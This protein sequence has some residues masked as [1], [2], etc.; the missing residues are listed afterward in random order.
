M[1][2]SYFNAG[3]VVYSEDG[4]AIADTYTAIGRLGSNFMDI[5]T[6]S[7]ALQAGESNVGTPL[8][9]PKLQTPV[10]GL[11]VPV[12]D[13]RGRV[14]G[15][16]TGII[17]LSTPNFLN[18]VSQH[19]YGKTGGYMLVAQK[20][21]MIVTATD[22]SRAME[23]LPPP[24]VN[25][26]VD[27]L[28]SGTEGSG[29]ATNALGVEVLG[30]AKGIPASGWVV[31]ATL[32]TA[33]AFASIHN[34]KQ[35]MWRVTGGLT[36]LAGLLAW[37][38]IRRLLAPLAT[39]ASTLAGM[40]NSENPAQHLP[41]GRHDEIGLVVGGFNRLLTTLAHRKEALKRSEQKFH[42]ILEN[43]EAYI[44]L[45][46]THSRY[47]FVNR[48]MRRLLGM[49]M[50][51]IVG[52][53]DEAISDAT[54]AAQ[55]RA[56]DLRVLTEGITLRTDETIVSSTTNRTF[57]HISVKLPLRNEA[58]EIYALCGISTD[59]TDR[60]LAEEALRIAAI[61]FECQEGMVVL[62]PDWTVLRVNGAFTQ[63][64]GYTREEVEG[65]TST[66]AVAALR[67]H[68]ESRA[69]WDHLQVHGTLQADLW[70]KHKNGQRYLCRANVTAV[71][72][73]KNEIT[74]YVG[75]FVDAT[76]FYLQ[77][78]KNQQ[79]ETVHRDALVREVHHRIKNN[80]Q[81]ITGLLHQFSV[82]HPE[83]REP[84]SQA[85]SQVRSIAVLHGLQGRKSLD[86]VRLCEL[87]SAIA[88]DVEAVWRTPISVDIPHSWTPGIV[89]EYEA[90]P[91]ALVINE[92][93]VNAVKHST[94]AGAP[95]L[96]TLRKG[97]RP[98]WIQISIQNVGQL[99]HSADCVQHKH[100]GLQLVDTLMPRY[101]V[102]VT[103][104]QA[105]NAV[106]T[107]LEVTPPVITLEEMELH[108]LQ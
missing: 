85:I 68:A 49:D 20:Q 8:L 2:K 69:A 66:F 57:T 101:G 15:A 64:T 88:S 58:G 6:V 65:K 37:W 59:I 98:D 14:I 31:V 23:A 29:I 89:A 46:D 78:Q 12:R 11:S 63:I 13:G 81:G 67:L 30:S 45:K 95:V 7:R 90:V 105:G 41:I 24:G 100:V 3:M 47:L 96:V 32:P 54:T 77:E 82:V 72:D 19:H 73:D 36:L 79:H 87:T 70:H 91:M 108:A 99:E 60:K 104:E 18:Q 103:R 75:N 10:V 16:L 42:D 74:H 35:H 55:L 97:G 62:D 21:R 48:A 86:T 83:T 39:A 107:L 80:L 17:D 40:S 102:T 56:N 94:K 27:S 43:V 4:I 22:P 84:I 76:A 50:E 9:G 92:L 44:Y 71:R 1:L 61:A 51:D 106:I 5:E 28:V 53:T 33:E 26:L 93:L 34:M 25:A 52:K 38:M